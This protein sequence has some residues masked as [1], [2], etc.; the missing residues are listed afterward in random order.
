MGLSEDIPQ[1]HGGISAQESLHRILKHLIS[2]FGH[3]LCLPCRGQGD[4]Y[5]QLVPQGPY[6]EGLEIN[7]VPL[8]TVSIFFLG[9]ANHLTKCSVDV[10][11]YPMFF[12]CKHSKT[13]CLRLCS[14][15]TGI[16]VRHASTC[17]RRVAATSAALLRIFPRY[18]YATIRV[19]SSFIPAH[20]QSESRL[21]SWKKRTIS[22]NHSTTGGIFQ[23]VKV[24]I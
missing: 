11:Q 22:Q 17:P 7:L 20:V 13:P 3:R 12:P 24:A 4:S 15:R 23:E 21:V 2:S 18:R 6:C 16:H 10:K 8:A 1:V 9:R 5:L 19:M 14:P